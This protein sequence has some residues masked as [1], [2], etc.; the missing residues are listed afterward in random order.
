MATLRWDH[1]VHYV[2]HLD[3]AIATFTDNQLVAFPGGAHPGWG[4]HNALS[5]FGLTY[6][7]FL[8]IRD[9][10]ELEQA[11][12]FLLSQ[13]AKRLL[14]QQQVLYRVALRS[15]DI[16]AT[17]QALLEQG[18]TLSPIVEGKRHDKQGNLIEWRIFTIS[19][20]LQGVP[21]PFVLQWK[22]NDA[23]R[24]DFLRTNNID[25]PHPVG[26]A[27]L[28][29]AVF[30]VQHPEQVA[31]HWQRLFQFSA[32]EHT[33]TTLYIGEQQLTFQP[34]EENRL[35]ALQI[36]TDNDAVKGT[37]VILGGGEYQFV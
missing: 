19:G 7:E 20:D 37:S 1:A 21:Y 18:L 17:H 35:T 9:A 2:N 26:Q 33:P 28:Q 36:A 23:A 32:S 29:A 15:D 6:L 13:D 34:G 14:P 24:L 10:Q 31:Q 25:R 27:L 11:Q 5:Y 12:D 4:T 8:S 3:D 22:T 30:T 16:D